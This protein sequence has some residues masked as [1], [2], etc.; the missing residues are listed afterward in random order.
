[1]HRRPIRCR[2]CETQYSVTSVP[3]R[4]CVSGSNDPLGQFELPST[5][6]VERGC[7][8]STAGSPVRWLQTAALRRRLPATD[9]PRWAWRIWESA[10]RRR[11]GDWRRMRQDWPPAVTANENTAI[12]GVPASAAALPRSPYQGCAPFRSDLASGVGCERGRSSEPLAAN[13]SGGLPGRQRSLIF[14]QVRA[15][16]CGRRTQWLRRGPAIYSVTS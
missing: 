2:N 5:D 13:E 9:P 12:A 8:V 7:A 14:G 4:R 6:F 3:T 15:R 1:M 16:L 10:H 11:H